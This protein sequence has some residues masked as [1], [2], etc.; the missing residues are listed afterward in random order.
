MLAKL[1]PVH[2]NRLLL[3]LPLAAKEVFVVVAVMEHVTKQ[4]LPIVLYCACVNACARARVLLSL[5]DA[6]AASP[7]PPTNI[8]TPSS[9]GARG[10]R[11]QQQRK[12]KRRVRRFDEFM[13]A[14]EVAAGLALGSLLRGTPRVNAHNCRESYLTVE[15]LSAD[16]LLTGKHQNRTVG[17]HRHVAS[18]AS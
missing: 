15:G 9:G 4:L 18:D 17:T 10:T 14:E 8:S 6:S 11:K 1:Q 5:A 16:V 7:P 2:A 13:A 3:L 12:G